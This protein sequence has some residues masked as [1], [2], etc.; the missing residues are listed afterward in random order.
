MSIS[1]LP[2][3]RRPQHST[4]VSVWLATVQATARRVTTTTRHSHS[5]A[6]LQSARPDEAD[7]TAEAAG[8][9]DCAV[10]APRVAR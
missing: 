6:G 4:F 7:M 9:V 2:G 3:T 8:R 10:V 5:L 1:R